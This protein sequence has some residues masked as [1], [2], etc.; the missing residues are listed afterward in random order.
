MIKDA[1]TRLWKAA[2]HATPNGSLS[3]PVDADHDIGFIAQKSQRLDASGK[4]IR[5]LIV[6]TDSTIG[7][8]AAGRYEQSPRGKGN[9]RR[10]EST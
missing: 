7:G 1:Y 4:R 8:V 5:V 9:W 2:R 3:I 6:S 10:V